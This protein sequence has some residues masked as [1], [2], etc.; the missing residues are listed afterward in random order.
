MKKPFFLFG[1]ILAGVFQIT[2]FDSLKVFNVKPDFILLAVV[3]AYFMLEFKW[4]ISLSVFAG[5]IKDALGIGAFGMN[6]LLFPLW[7]F[8]LAKVNKQIQMDSSLFRPIV[9]FVITLSHHIIAGLI[10]V[11]L[12]RFI[13]IGIFLRIVFI[14]SI[15]TALIFFLA[16]KLAAQWFPAKFAEVTE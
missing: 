12:G 16:C 14:E 2:L 3:M 8:L 13:P 4:A 11:T 1:I 15:Y 6:T 10:F 9:V 7:V 5:I